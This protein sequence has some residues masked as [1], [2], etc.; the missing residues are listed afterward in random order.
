MKVC[1][2]NSGHLLDLE[3]TPNGLISNNEAI[4]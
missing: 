1:P 4:S 2:E 3:P